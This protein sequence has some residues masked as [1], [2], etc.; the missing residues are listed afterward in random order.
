MTIKDI[1]KYIESEYKV[2]N[3]TPCEI[4]GGDYIAEDLEIALIDGI[5][6]DICDC[7]CSSCGHEKEFLFTAPF[8]EDKDYK[9]IVKT[10]N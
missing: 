2:I 1:M 3:E 4:C 8:I 9:K 5:P 10:L 7:I 6:F